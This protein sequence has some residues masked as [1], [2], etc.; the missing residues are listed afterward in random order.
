M[1]NASGDLGSRGRPCG[2]RGPDGLRLRL[3]V[4]VLAE[5]RPGR[6]WILLPLLSL[7][8]AVWTTRLVFITRPA[9]VE[10]VSPKTAAVGL[11]YAMLLSAGLIVGR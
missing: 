2:V 3:A 11:L 9:D 8:L 7:P 1:A 6:K 5:S 4:L 10:P